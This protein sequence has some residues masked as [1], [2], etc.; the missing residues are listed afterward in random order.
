[1][2]GRNHT[3][4]NRF[5]LWRNK[6]LYSMALP[7]LTLLLVFCYLPMIGIILPFKNLQYDK[8]ILGSEW[9]KPL[10]YNFKYLFDSDASIRAIRNTLILNSLFIATGTVFNVTLALLIN[11]IRSPLFR[12]ISQSLTLLPFFVS[13]IVVSIFVS[14]FINVDTGTLN[15]WLKSAGRKPIDFYT[16]PSYWPGILIFTNI[17][18]SSGFGCIVYLATLTGI[19]ATLYEAAVIDGASKPQQVRYIS[20]PL[21]VPTIVI[22]CLLAVG[23][24]MNA[25]FGMFYML[26]GDSPTLYKTTDVMDT[27]VFRSLRQTGD[28][29]M[30]SA[31]GLLQATTAFILI[32]ATNLIA[33]RIDRDSAL[34]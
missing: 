30:S 13:W 24:I 12:R 28:I 27:F 14:A 22:L 6:S 17:W 21:L 9:S 33:R 26:T 5:D 3:G 19:D 2:T 32:M 1:M 34:F 11:E 8:G 16:E 31:A 7:G 18:K 29:G 10:F 4:L 25:D 20:L 23:R 15:H